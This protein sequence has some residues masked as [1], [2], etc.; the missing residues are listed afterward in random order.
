MLRSR[1]SFVCLLLTGCL[2]SKHEVA[3]ERPYVEE[4]AKRSFRETE[5]PKTMTRELESWYLEE[6]R[7]QDPKSTLTDA[8]LLAELERHLLDLELLLNPLDHHSLTNPRKFA[9]PHGGG[10]VDL[11]DVVNPGHGKF[12]AK[13][14]VPSRQSTDMVRVYYLSGAKQRDVQ[15]ESFGSGCGKWANLTK[16]YEHSM[17]GH[18]LELFVK[19][20]RYVSVLAGTWIVAVLK[21]TQLH[22]AGVLVGD[23]RYPR[24]QCAAI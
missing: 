8:E 18:G 24:L 21:G 13:I 2:F 1:L 9:L 15:G 5:V 4:S 22:I 12:T 10:I 23:S 17:A 6:R 16:W 14:A 20:Q 19:D 11:A 7:K 3:H